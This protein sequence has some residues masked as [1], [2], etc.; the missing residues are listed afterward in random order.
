MLPEVGGDLLGQVG[1]AVRAGVVDD[2]HVGL[3]RRGADAHARKLDHVA[4]PRCRSAARRRGARA[5]TL[6]AARRR[7]GTPRTARLPQLR[8]PRPCV[9]LRWSSRSPTACSPPTCPS[10]PRP[11]R[12]R[13]SPSSAAGSTALPSVIR[14]GVTVIAGRVPH[15]ARRSRAAGGRRPP[16]RPAAADPRRVPPARALARLRVHLGALAGHPADAVRR[17]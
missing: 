15:A 16:R 14:L 7:L 10:S 9:P 6:P 13:S 8:S 3:R 12:P 1:G 4:R 11:A 5:A 17:V 2:E